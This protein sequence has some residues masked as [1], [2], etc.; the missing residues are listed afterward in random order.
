M[1]KKVKDVRI[2]NRKAYFE[3]AIEIE[4]DAGIAL[5]GPEVKSVRDGKASISEAYCF[6]TDNGLRIKGMHIAEFKNAGYVEQEPTRERILLVN[7]HEL[8]KLRLKMKDQGNTIVPIELFFAD[9]GY[10]KLKIGLGRGKKNY[11][12]RQD[13]KSKD[14][15]REI[16]RFS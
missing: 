14:V 4:M 1:S 5:T 7:K 12:K 11:D 13:I 10:A 6:L 16:E 2:K 15:K 3:Y 9:S 8:K